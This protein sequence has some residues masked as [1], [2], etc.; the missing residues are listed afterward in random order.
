MADACVIVGGGLA[1]MVAARRL[2]QLDVRPVILERG[3]VE[4]GANNARISG[5]LLHVAMAAMDEKPESLYNRL[6]EETDGEIDPDLARVYAENAGRATNWLLAEGVEIK[7]KSPVPCQ[8]FALFPHELGTARRFVPTRG[9]DRAMMTL[10][11][12]ARANGAE[13]I[14]GAAAEGL[15]PGAGGGWILTYR[16]GGGRRERTARAVLVADG[17]F[18]GNPEMLARYVGP[19]AG[20]CLPR[21]MPG[22]TGAGLR[23]LMAVGAKALGLGRVYGHMVSADALANDTLW[24]YPSVD[25]LCLQ[26]VL[27]D[28]RGD[29]FAT[30][31]SDGVRL[32]TELART[33]DPRGY[34]VI[35]D[36]ALWTTAGKDN[37]Y[38][39]PVPNPDLAER[40]GTLVEGASVAALGE[41]TGIEADRLERAVAEHNADPAR[42]ALAR[43]PFYAMPVVPGITFTMGGV[44]IGLACEVLDEMDRPI[45]GLY[46]AGG[47]T[48]GLHGGPRGGYVGG[49]A[50]ALTFGL[51]A[52]EAIAPYVR[53]G[54]VPAPSRA[55]RSRRAR[56]R[57]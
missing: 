2:Q 11:R 7:P 34:R 51:L 31:A 30:R 22:S 10:Y 55:T 50:A 53:R 21:A 23:M 28:R 9:P 47:T 6:L 4:G 38:G 20:Q 1:G 19:N 29:R 36:E 3:E 45:A 44:R 33:E 35:F 54:S 42:V 26:G 5:G 17:G 41:A 18:Q 15:R 16:I 14:L 57:A 27:V 48:G 56:G 52:A 32:V 39:T 37:P 13:V 49:L 24:P 8:R 43:P 40:G 25:K 46:A 12:A